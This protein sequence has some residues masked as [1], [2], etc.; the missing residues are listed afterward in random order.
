MMASWHAQACR[1]LALPAVPQGLS[2]ASAPA[3]PA[4]SSRPIRRCRRP[5]CRSISFCSAPTRVGQKLHPFP[6]FLA[7]VCQLRPQSRGIVRIKSA[8]PAQPPAIQP[9]YLSAQADR[10]THRRRHEAAAPD[11]GRAGDRAATS[12]RSSTRARSATATRICWRSRATRAR[13]CFIRPAPAGWDRT[14]KRSSTSGCGCAASTACAS[15]DASIMPTVVSGNTNAAVDHDRREGRRH[16]CAGGA[17]GHYMVIAREG[18]QSST[19]HR[20]PVFTGSS[21]CA[22]DDN[23]ECV[24]TH[25]K[26]ASHYSF[27]YSETIAVAS[28]SLLPEATRRR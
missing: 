15:I 6:G 10:D 20:L 18:G 24:A 3:M 19:P 5:T 2:H 12:P 26:T 8:D 13:R 11:H 28:S 1:R 7:S 14:R 22:D 25:M 17:V 23:Q 21:A 4:A 16:D 27:G 9:H